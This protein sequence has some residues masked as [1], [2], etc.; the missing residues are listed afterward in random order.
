MK[1]L[2]FNL[3][4]VIYIPIVAAFDEA[5]LLGLLVTVIG[6]FLIKLVNKQE[7]MNKKIDAIILNQAKYDLMMQHLDDRLTELE[8]DFKNNFK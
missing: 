6:F 5:Q 1:T 4:P 7:E 8:L 3:L 2:L